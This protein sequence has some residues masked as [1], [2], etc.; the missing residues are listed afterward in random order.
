[1]PTSESPRSRKAGRDCFLPVQPQYPWHWNPHQGPSCVDWSSNP[2]SR[3][4]H[5]H[6]L[7]RL[8][9]SHRRHSATAGHTASLA[10]AL[11][12]ALLFNFGCSPPTTTGEEPGMMARLATAVSN[13]RAVPVHVR[14]LVVGYH[15][16]RSV[17]GALSREVVPG[18]VLAIV[19]PNGSG[20]T[21]LFRTLLGVLAPLSGEVQISGLDPGHYRRT[22]GLGYLSEGTPMPDGWSCDGILSLAAAAAEPDADIPNALRLVGA[23]Y[24]TDVPASKVSK[25]MKR[26]LALAIALIRPIKMLILDEPESGLDPGQRHRLRRRIE[27]LRRPMTM[28]GGQSRSRRTRADERPSP[29][30][31]QGRGKLVE[32]P[33]GGFTRDFLEHE[34]LA[35][36][37]AITADSNSS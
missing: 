14:D 25:G 1:M 2:P 8:T 37:G 21:T 26:R 31:D 16:S 17:L 27:R 12:P 20:K 19:G 33:S 36:E 3:R 28:L 15:Q 30:I 10:K 5:A 11:Q 24:A 6:F 18:E 32:Q 35:L 23:D 9:P 22:R 34:F 13:P 7:H 29:L 4:W